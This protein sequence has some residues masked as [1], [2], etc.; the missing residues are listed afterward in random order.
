MA[1]IDTNIV[2]RLI[3]QDSDEQVSKINDYISKQSAGKLILEDAVLFEVVWILSGSN[4]QLSRQLVAKALLKIAGITQI[5]CNRPLL[6]KALPI[7]VKHPKLS[8]VDICLACYAELNNAT[9][10]LTF[11]KALAKT[12]PNSQFLINKP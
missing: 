10:L 11:D 8:F 6:F 3:L 7:Y 12:L 2:L 5:R 9:P 4:Y 1:S